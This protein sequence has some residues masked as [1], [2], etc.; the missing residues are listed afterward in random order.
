METEKI[1]KIRELKREMIDNNE[2]IIEAFSTLTDDMLDV[3]KYALDVL[4][5]RNKVLKKII[6]KLQGK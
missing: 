3:N 2:L 4:R 5:K 6:K 1:I